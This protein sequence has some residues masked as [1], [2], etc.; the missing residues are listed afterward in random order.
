M[1]SLPYWAVYSPDGKRLLALS[2]SLQG[3]LAAAEAGREL[4]RMIVQ[5]MLDRRAQ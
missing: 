3:A 1:W 5:K 2:E 4:S